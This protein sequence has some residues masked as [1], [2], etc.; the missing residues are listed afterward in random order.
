[1]Y[2]NPGKRSAALAGLQDLQRS[3]PTRDALCTCLDRR[4]LEPPVYDLGLN[5]D[6]DAFAELLDR[7][8]PFQRF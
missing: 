8:Q 7:R 2:D 6:E 4:P 3:N 5:M 1:M